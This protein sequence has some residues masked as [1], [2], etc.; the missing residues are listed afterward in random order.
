[1]DGVGW[2]KSRVLKIP[3]N[4]EIIYLPPYSPEIKTVEVLWKYIKDNVLKNKIY[5][6]LKILEEE[7]CKFI[8]QIKNETYRSICG[9]DYMLN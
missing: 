1:M 5:E 9:V 8:N 3:K 2:H 7:L 6:N 4:I